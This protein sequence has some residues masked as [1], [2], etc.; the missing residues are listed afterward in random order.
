MISTARDEIIKLVY[1]GLKADAETVSMPILYEDVDGDKP[2]SGDISWCR[3]SVKHV[4]G[5]QSTLSN[6]NGIRRYKRTGI[7][8]VQLF[9][10]I[11]TGMSLSDKYSKIIVDSLDGKS[12]TSGVWLRNVR[13]NEVG[14]DG[15]WFQTNIFADFEYE[16]EK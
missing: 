14:R 5:N 11:G 9:A 3:I 6:N 13:V 12:T 7:L 4:T 16:E 8:I 1:D 10:G 2:S 15:S